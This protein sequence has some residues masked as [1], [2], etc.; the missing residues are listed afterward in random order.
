MNVFIAWKVISCGKFFKRRL[1]QTTNKPFIQIHVGKLWSR[2]GERLS[3]LST[4]SRDLGRVT[5][6]KEALSTWSLSYKPQNRNWEK[7]CTRHSKFFRNTCYWY[8]NHL[9][10]LQAQSIRNPPEDRKT[11]CTQWSLKS[12]LG[13][14]PSFANWCNTKKKLVIRIEL[15]FEIYKMIYKSNNCPWVQ[16]LINLLYN[17]KSY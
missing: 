2:S 8:I 6:D 5:Q 3:H 1:T 11:A 9:F 16:G 4:R 13:S 14:S 7:N 15:W 17:L 10:H 12:V